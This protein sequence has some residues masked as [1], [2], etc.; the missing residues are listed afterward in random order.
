MQRSESLF[1]ST[2]QYCD[3]FVQIALS[4]MFF[5]A[6]SVSRDELAILT[7]RPHLLPAGLTINA[8]HGEAG[9]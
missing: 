2:R 8:T 3:F 1:E 4:Q 9:P 7:P 6:D 5:Y